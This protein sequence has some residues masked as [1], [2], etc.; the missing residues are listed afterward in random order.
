VPEAERPGRFRRLLI[1]R[2]TAA[3]IVAE[4]TGE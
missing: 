1:E 2:L 3:T 4:L